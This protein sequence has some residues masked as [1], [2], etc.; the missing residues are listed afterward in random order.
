MPRAEDSVEVGLL[1]AGGGSAD[2]APSDERGRVT[3][4]VFPEQ[5]KIGALLSNAEGGPS[6]LCYALYGLCPLTGLMIFGLVARGAGGME[7]SAAALNCIAGALGG[8]GFAALA[9]AVSSARGALRLPGGQLD[10][11]GV[12]TATVSAEEA[13]STARWRKGLLGLSA[14]FVLG[15]LSIWYGG[16]RGDRLRRRCV[17]RDS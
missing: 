10:E 5:R 9:L 8:L 13:A 2:P 6:P 11:L 12:G 17:W 4:E 15:G 7:S 3:L 14:L 16:S 1:A